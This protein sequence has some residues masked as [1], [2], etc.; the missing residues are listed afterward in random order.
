L[1][2]INITDISSKESLESIVQEYIRLSNYTWYKFSKNVN[3]TRYSMA[4]WNKEY[5]IKLNTYHLSKSLKDWKKFKKF[6]KQTKYSFFDEKI[7]E[8]M[9]KNKR[10]W[11]LMNWVKK[12]KLPAIKALQYNGHSC[13]ELE[14]L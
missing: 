3:I 5:S 4:W 13:T 1:K 2:N 12:Y 7:Q 9:L 14:N 8:I 11:N 10:P 6:I